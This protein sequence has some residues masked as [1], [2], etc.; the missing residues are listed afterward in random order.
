VPNHNKSILT[1]G[2]IYDT[3]VNDMTKSRKRLDKVKQNPRNVPLG[4][5]EALARLYGTIKEGTKHPRV[6]ITG[7]PSIPYKRES[8]VKKCYVDEL[9]EAIE[10]SEKE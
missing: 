6:A 9:L 7:Q 8:P 10:K 1:P 4:D 3:I 5:F 2:I